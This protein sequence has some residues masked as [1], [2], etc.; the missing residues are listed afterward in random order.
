M[1][2]GLP[3]ITPDVSATSSPEEQAGASSSQSSGRSKGYKIQ[4]APIKPTEFSISDAFDLFRDIRRKTFANSDFSIDVLDDAIT[5]EWQETSFEERCTYYRKAWINYEAQLS[6]YHLNMSRRKVLPSEER[7]DKETP[8]EEVPLATNIVSDKVDTD[9][10]TLEVRE[11]Y[12]DNDILVIDKPAGLACMASQSGQDT[13][14]ER[15]KKEHSVA[16]LPHRLDKAT[17]G[18]MVVAL[19]TASTR[20]LCGQFRNRQ[21]HKKYTAEVWRNPDPAQGPILLPL[22][23]D[24]GSCRQSIA[25]SQGQLSLTLYQTT[26]NHRDSCARVKLEPVTGR[27]HQ[28]RAHMAAIGHPIVGCSFYGNQESVSAGKRLHLHAS[29]LEFKHPVTGRIMSFERKPDF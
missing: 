2:T 5:K 26:K 19:N 7:Q 1:N 20:H 11:L 3:Q 6:L 9:T 12:K 4:P 21:V 25:Q 24:A 29:E 10:C 16:S 14:L 23:Y 13:M 28:L 27:T 8:G 15:L 17:S 22:K 18:L